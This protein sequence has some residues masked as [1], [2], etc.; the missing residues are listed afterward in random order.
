MTPASSA[1]ALT[2]LLPPDRL[3][4]TVRLPSDAEWS[5][6][7][8]LP[9]ESGATPKEKHMGVKGV[10]PWGSEWPPPA[11]AGNYEASLKLHSFDGTAPVGSF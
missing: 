11:G 4:Q 1:P 5:L 3:N 2:R 7:A 9:A 8:G 10:Y 6:A